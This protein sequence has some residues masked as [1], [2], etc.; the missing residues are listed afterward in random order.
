MSTSEVAD[1]PLQQNLKTTSLG[2]QSS[3]NGGS[4][5]ANPSDRKIA[6]LSGHDS[7]AIDDGQPCRSSTSQRY[8]NDSTGRDAECMKDVVSN[9]CSQLDVLD[10]IT[11]GS[12]FSYRL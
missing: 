5:G 8:D 9:E 1:T 4:G 10:E 12:I 11:A 2:T 7:T 6:T 3:R